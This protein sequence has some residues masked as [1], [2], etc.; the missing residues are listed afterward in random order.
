MKVVFFA[1][2]L[3]TTALL[4]QVVGNWRNTTHELELCSRLLI[5][6]DRV[7]RLLAEKP[8]EH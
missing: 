3:L 1:L 8:D 2:W 4:G 5:A 7:D 6:A